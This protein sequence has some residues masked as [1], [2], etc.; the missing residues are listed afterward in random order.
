MNRT[1]ILHRTADLSVRRFDHPEHEAHHDPD[2]EIGQHWSI[3]FVQSGCFA[4][5]VD[6]QEHRLGAGSVLLEQPG[7]P[8]TCRHGEECPD[9][10]CLSIGFEAE[11]VTQVEHAWARS[12]WAARVRPTPRLALVQQRLLD[13]AHHADSFELERWGLAAL[14][15]LQVDARDDRARGPYAPRQGDVDAVVATCRAIEADPTANLSIAV[16]ARAVG[17]SSTVL[18]HTFRRYLGLSPHQYVIRWRVVRSTSLLDA[19]HSVSDSCYRAGFENLSHYCR[20]FHRALGMR[21][22]AWRTLPLSERRRKVQDLL[23][24]VP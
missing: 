13:A 8:F 18:T 11:A 12:G 2:R 15:A 17:I 23:R 3:A 7:V 20:T 5:E 1:T 21:A 10:V 19:G 24:S 14:T 16:R 22:S 9:D 4:V 6:G